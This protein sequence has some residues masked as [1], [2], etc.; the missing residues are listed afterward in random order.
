MKTII[1]AARPRKRALAAVAFALTFAA[2][3]CTPPPAP[4]PLA[5]HGVAS[6]EA[7]TAEYSA[8]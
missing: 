4:A 5:S 1:E 6:N 7:W 2:M 3:G 8:Y